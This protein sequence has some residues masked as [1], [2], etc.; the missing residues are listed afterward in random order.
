MQVSIDVMIMYTT[1][2]FPFKADAL[3][4]SKVFKLILQWFFCNSGK[5]HELEV[6]RVNTCAIS[7]ILDGVYRI[8]PL[9]GKAVTLS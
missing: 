2:H 9:T 5:E 3:K 7:V 6:V 8:N 4:P 1:T